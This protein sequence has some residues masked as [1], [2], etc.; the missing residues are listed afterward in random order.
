MSKGMTR[1][2]FLGASGL[3]A[4]GCLAAPR[5]AEGGRPKPLAVGC[6]ATHLRFTGEKDCWTAMRRVG[7]EVAEVTIREDLSL[8]EFFHPDRKC[9][10]ATDDGVKRLAADL[11]AAKVRISAFCMFTRYDERPDF[12]LE[13]AAKVAR[14]AQALGVPVIRIDVVPRKIKGEPFLDFA[15]ATLKKVLAATEPT[16]VAFGIENHGRTTNRPEF[17]KPLFE[18]V[19]S[20][21]LGL[22]LDT[23]NFYWY[24]HPLSRLYE[25]YAAFASRVFHTHCKSIAYPADQR[26]RQRPIGWQ[27]G[28]YHCPI[29]EG[30]IDFR[31]VVAILRKAGYDNDLCVEDESLGK[32][33]AADRPAILAREIRLLKSLRGDRR[34]HLPKQG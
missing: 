23:G 28:K 33:P 9:S 30:D 8:P 21:R 7:A 18:R 5:G 6:R 29:D 27:Y 19:G 20:E 14:V 1:R 4:T 31:R 24:G 16:G 25:I 34:P 10:A 2:A 17:L 15:V 11:D 12:E 13:W 3:L 26:E 22:T 32:R